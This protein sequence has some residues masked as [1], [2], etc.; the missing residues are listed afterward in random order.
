M[1][2]TEYYIAAGKVITGNYI[3]NYYKFEDSFIR[4]GSLREDIGYVLI[5]A[6]GMEELNKSASTHKAMDQII[7][8]F[9]DKETLVIDLRFCN[10]GFDEASLLI[11]SYFTQKSYLAYK[12]QVYYKGKYAELQDIYVKPGKLYFDGKVVILTSGYTVSAAETLI[13]AMIADPD[14]RI[15]IVGE[16]TAGFY[17]DGIPKILPSGFYFAMSSER[18]LWYDDTLLEGKGVVPQVEIPID[19][20]QAHLGQ[21]QALNWVLENY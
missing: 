17:S 6:L 14:H 12:K 10:G 1:L 11:S 18:Y 8:E 7:E 21:D 3:K 19:Q 5:H 9:K 15:T 16:E 2:S 4:Y 20:S 13:R